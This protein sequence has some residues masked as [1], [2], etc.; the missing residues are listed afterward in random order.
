M[1]GLLSRVL[2]TQQAQ[3]IVTDVIKEPLVPSGNTFSYIPLLVIILVLSFNNCICE[4]GQ[5][6]LPLRSA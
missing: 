5:W 1:Y 6:F 3:S 4:T 2:G